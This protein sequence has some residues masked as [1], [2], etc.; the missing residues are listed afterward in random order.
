M[1]RTEK[2]YVLLPQQVRYCSDLPASAKLFFAEIA[3]QANEAG[4]IMI[5]NQLLADFFRVDKQSIYYWVTA[6][7][8]AGFLKCEI[9]RIRKVHYRVFKILI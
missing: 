1:E 8:K 2:D 3:A 4:F 7:E 6:L 5:D 9:K